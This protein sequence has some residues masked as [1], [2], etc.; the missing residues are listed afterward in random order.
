MNRFF[1]SLFFILT[2]TFTLQA[3]TDTAKRIDELLTKYLEYEKFNGA[4]LVAD[5]SGIIFQDGYGK[6]D[7]EWGINFTPETKFRIGSVTKQF[8]SMVIMQLAQEGKLNVQDKLIQHLPWYREDTG[9]KIT[10]QHL[11]VHTSGIPSYTSAADFF[12]DEGMD[13]LTPKELV[14]KLCMG[15][16]E[17]EPGE[18]WAYNNSGYVI[19]GAIIE[20]IEGKS[21]GEV[22]L[23]RIFEPL[24]MN[25]SGYDS[26]IQ[27][28]PERASGYSQNFNGFTNAQYINMSTPYAAGAL[29]STVEDLYKWDR[30]LYTTALLSKEN[31]AKYFTPVSSSY[32]Y[33]WFIE[34]FNLEDGSENLKLLEHGGGINGFSSLITRD[35]LNQNLVVLLSNV[36]GTSLRGI[37]RNI[38]KILYGKSIEYPKQSIAKFLY[39]YEQKNPQENLE[40]I[41]N[42][43]LEEEESAF[44][45]SER[46]LNSL[47]YAFK[48]EGKLKKAF[49]I[50]NINVLKYPQSSNVYDSRGEIYLALGDTTNSISDYKKSFE[51]NPGNTNAKEI[52]AQLGIELEENV[53]ISA[54]DI[55]LYPGVYEVS[56][57][58]KLTVRTD[59]NR[60]FV[61]ATAQPE[62]E[63]FPINKKKFY[64]KVV[65]AQVEFNINGGETESLT[66]YQNG[67]VVPARKV[68]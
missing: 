38:L 35:T 21:Y 56:P 68:E 15:D 2:V 26:F 47:G 10:I 63:L 18:K 12:V 65:N 9:G 32:A 6:A 28:I 44:E 51:L 24:N 34:E 41:F 5:S 39:E 11:L 33:G 20:E 60:I 3:Q 57:Q 66:L 14:T 43:L 40:S 59:G 45:V 4:L 17:F 64:L 27:I 7:F 50:F 29:Y 48:N 53:T 62:F 25:N 58:F 1:R 42:T 67:A 49:T 61:Q 30:A 46:E 23:E 8:T 36:D 16:L 37:S 31:M 55:E 13:N 19:L 54:K 22:L 52:L